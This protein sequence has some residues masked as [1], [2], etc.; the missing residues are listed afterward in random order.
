MLAILKERRNIPIE[1]RKFRERKNEM[2]DTRN[3]KTIAIKRATGETKIF[4][5]FF[6]RHHNAAAKA[7]LAAK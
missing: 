5:G 1:A 7:W 3:F 4:Y 2:T 6:V